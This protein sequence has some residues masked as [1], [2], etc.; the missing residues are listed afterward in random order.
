MS[1]QLQTT[2]FEDLK[3]AAWARTSPV[4]ETAAASWEFRKDCLGNLVRY[5]DYGRRNSPFGWEL[6][7]IVPLRRGGSA[8][9]ENLQALHW[10]A[11]AARSEAVPR[12]VLATPTAQTV[13]A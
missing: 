8:D 11:S 7:Y 5:N 2:L 4:S 1:S 12:G 9:P 6:E 3:R 10:K 13:L